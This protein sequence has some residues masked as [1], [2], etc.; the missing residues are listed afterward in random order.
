MS[1]IVEKGVQELMGVVYR[2]GLISATHDATAAVLQS[3]VSFIS[4]GTPSQKNGRLD[5]AHVR[6]VCTDIGQALRMKE[7]FHCIVLRSTVLPGTTES[8]VVPALEAASGKRAGRDFLV[9]FNPE[10]LREGTAVA[11]FF[12]PPF[13]VIGTDDPVMAAPVREL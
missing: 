6:N 1:L 10:F 8:V 4:V 12:N 7:S 3:E 11:D 9:C 2:N 5:L 13:T